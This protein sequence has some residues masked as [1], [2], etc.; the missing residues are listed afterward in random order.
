MKKFII[1]AIIALTFI[2]CSKERPVQQKTTETYLF[3]AEAVSIDG[4]IQY[5]NVVSIT[6]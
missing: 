1:V 3:R 4:A 6:L 5:S 2:G